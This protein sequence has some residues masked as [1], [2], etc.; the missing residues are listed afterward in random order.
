MFN[1]EHR[2]F[3]RTRVM[4]IKPAMRLAIRPDQRMIVRPNLGHAPTVNLIE[5]AID[6][7]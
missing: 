6:L 4:V 2:A 7:D 5:R 3:H 1:I